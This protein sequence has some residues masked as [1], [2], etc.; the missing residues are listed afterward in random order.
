[1]RVKFFAQRYAWF[2]VGVPAM[3]GIAHTLFTAVTSPQTQTG[4]DMSEAARQAQIAACE[5]E[6]GYKNTEDCYK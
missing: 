6:K 2:I 1:M 5:S 3:V 4:K